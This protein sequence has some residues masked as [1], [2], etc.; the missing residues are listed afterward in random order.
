MSTY[1]LQQRLRELE[2]ELRAVKQER[3]KYVK[4]LENRKERE[5]SDNIEE[6]S[7][8][9]IYL[10]HYIYKRIH[11]LSNNKEDS[12]T[13]EQLEKRIEE[14]INYVCSCRW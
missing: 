6:L 10:S 11:S 9:P 13:K 7:N 12:L 3:E 4:I 1:E 2:K 14:A 5:L 8:I